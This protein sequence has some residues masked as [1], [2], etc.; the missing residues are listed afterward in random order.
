MP[1]RVHIALEILARGLTDF[2]PHPP[3][4]NIAQPITHQT[5]TLRQRKGRTPPPSRDHIISSRDNIRSGWGQGGRGTRVRVGGSKWGGGGEGS[6]ATT[7]TTRVH[8][9]IRPSRLRRARPKKACAQSRRSERICVADNTTQQ[10]L[11]K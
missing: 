3:K 11:Q 10:M 6:C 5:S 4:P 9:S 7:T 1:F 8:D 2:S